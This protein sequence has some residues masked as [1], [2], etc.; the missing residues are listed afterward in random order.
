MFGRCGLI[1]P[2]FLSCCICWERI[3]YRW[4][5]SCRVGDRTS[6]GAP[7]RGH[8]LPETVGIG[9]GHELRTFITC[10]LATPQRCSILAD[11]WERVVKG[12]DRIMI[13]V[14]CN[15]KD[16]G[17]VMAVADRWYHWYHWNGYFTKCYC[18]GSWGSYIQVFNCALTG[19]RKDFCICVT[20]KEF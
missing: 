14:L 20:I 17:A 18:G 16:L 3:P 19:G 1:D 9:L 12:S 5:R 10:V 6:S 4:G 15:F 11:L 2:M 8:M 13:E 7:G